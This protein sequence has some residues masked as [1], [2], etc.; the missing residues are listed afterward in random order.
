V[1]AAYAYFTG[2]DASA[3]IDIDDDGTDEASVNFEG[4]NSS[5]GDDATTGDSGDDSPVNGY[6]SADGLDVGVADGEPSVSED[7]ERQ[8]DPT[9]DAVAEKDDLED[10][11]GIG[12][13]RADDLHNAGYETP[14][15]L[16]YAS[17]D[18]LE[19]V[20]GLGPR[21]VENIRSDIGS[22]DSE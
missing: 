5:S 14:A 4:E 20:H 22:V 12:P 3:G 7:V 9:P 6:Q 1:A 17:D 15:D 19:A 8:A 13:T 2:N 21:A 16:Y 18:N 10:V 11:K